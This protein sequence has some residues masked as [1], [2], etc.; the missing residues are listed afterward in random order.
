MERSTTGETR[1]LHPSSVL[2][3]DGGEWDFLATGD[4]LGPQATDTEFGASRFT[5]QSTSPVIS[6]HFTA[7]A[8]DVAYYCV[9]NLSVHPGN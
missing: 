6:A 1:D 2:G 5:S 4:G 7:R 9:G 8:A 3:V